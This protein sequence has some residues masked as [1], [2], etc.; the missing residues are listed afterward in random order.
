MYGNLYDEPTKEDV[1][2]DEDDGEMPYFTVYTDPSQLLHLDM[3][4]SI[5]LESQIEEVYKPAIN[6]LVYSYLSLETVN[7]SEEARST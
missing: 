1:V 7:Q 3:I 4:W 2:E 5:V 6:L